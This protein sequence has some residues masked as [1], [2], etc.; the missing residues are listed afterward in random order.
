MAGRTSD[1]GASVASRLF[2]VLSAF[3][4]DRPVL[5]LT[6]ISHR[7]NLPLST[8]RRLIL[9]LVAWGG[10]ERLPN[11][12][13]RIGLRLWELGSL[14]PQQRGLREAALPFMN[15]LYEATRENVQL[16]VLDGH[17]ALCI[18]KIYGRTA[19]PT[20]TKVGER[21]PL[22]ATGVGKALLAF[23]PR[24]MLEALVDE[25]LTRMTPHTL[26]EA[27]RLSAALHEA[28]RSRLAFSR[29]EMSLGAVS[30]ASPILTGQGAPAG[31]IGIVARVGTSLDRLAPAVLTA[32][33]SLSRVLR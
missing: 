4:V 19:V 11:G 13:Y 23:S 3:D 30:V 26:I 9:E 32:A 14:A 31:A 25:G 6:D 1:P 29:E 28:R 8:T 33:L 16:M 7:S 22:H 27:G 2:D 21:A 18:E 10:L 12:T 5:S 17:T 20:E 15:D 24:S